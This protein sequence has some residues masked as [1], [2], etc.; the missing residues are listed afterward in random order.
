M[1]E[2]WQPFY[3]RLQSVRITI[4]GRGGAFNL[5]LMEEGR[6]LLIPKGIVKVKKIDVT[7]IQ[8]AVAEV[9]GDVS[10]PS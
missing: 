3:I 9:G 8:H 6:G 4:N 5:L 2:F 7:S 10:F 1:L